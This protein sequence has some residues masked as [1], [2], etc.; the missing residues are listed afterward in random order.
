MPRQATTGKQRSGCYGERS[1][2]HPWG[3]A[4]GLVPLFT[5]PWLH[6]W[7][8]TV[9]FYIVLGEFLFCGMPAPAARDLRLS[10]LQRW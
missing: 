6:F 2:R 10:P 3:G 9:L 7:Y 1:G 4:G 5:I 8:N